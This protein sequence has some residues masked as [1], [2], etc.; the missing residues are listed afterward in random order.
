MKYVI[1]GHMRRKE[2]APFFILSFLA[3]LTCFLPIEAFAQTAPDP[4][5]CGRGGGSINQIFCGIATEF[6]GAP[7]LLS[8]FSWVGAVIL[9]I[10]AFMN[11]KQH[12]DDPG[13]VP[14]RSIIIK[15]VLAVLLISLPLIMRVFITSVTGT[16]DISSAGV[17]KRPKL[18]T[19][20]IGGRN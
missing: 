13:S 20:S 12:G 4:L 8:V 3:C 19:G 15:F 18:G 1:V 14:M 9:A 16:T 5:G 7:K 10:M 6:R 2:L 11:L 17:V